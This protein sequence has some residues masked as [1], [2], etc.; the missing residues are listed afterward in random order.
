ME[1]SHTCNLWTYLET[2]ISKVKGQCR[3]VTLCVWQ[4]L[5]DNRERNDPRDTNNWLEGCQPHRQQCALSRPKVKGQGQRSQVTWSVWQVL[6][7][8]SRTKSPRDSKIGISRLPMP[9]TIVHTN[10]K[11]KMSKVNVTWP[12]GRLLLRPKVYHI[13]RTGRPTNVKISTPMEYTLSTTMA[14]ENGFCTR[15]GAYRVGHTR[16]PHN[17]FCLRWSPNRQIIFLL[18]YQ[19][20]CKAINQCL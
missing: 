13:Y 17:L 18:A 9:R 4:L 8:K 6:G 11:I 3:K 16:R 19:H 7:H 15:A 12:N 1:A 10:F 2:M 20:C 5:A 14:C